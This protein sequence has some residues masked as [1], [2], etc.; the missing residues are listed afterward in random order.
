MTLTDRAGLRYLGRHPWLTA[1][2]ILGIALGVSVV[3]SIDIAN[4][5]ARRSFELSAERVTGRATHHVA[6][7][8]DVSDEVFRRLRVDAGIRP[9]A[10]VVEGF[11]QIQ[12]GTFEVLGVD[13][14]FDRPFRVYATSI[15]GMDL[16]SFL[17][18]GAVVLLPNAAADLLGASV[19]D[20]LT[21]AAAGRT[22]RLVV[23]GL[24]QA[25]NEADGGAL[26]NFIVAD[27]GTAQRLFGM[28]GRLSRIDLMLPEDPDAIGEVES[29]LPEG[30]RLVESGAQTDTI[31]QMTRA[32]EVNLTALSLLALVVGMF[33]IYNTMTFSVVQRR[34][35]I[36]RMR[37]IGVTRSEIFR[38]ILFE[39]GVLG[40]AGTVVGLAGGVALSLSLVRMVTQTIND[41]YYVVD[42]QSV[43]VDP[44]IL[45]KGTAL[46][47]GATI[48][49]A[50]WPAREA[51]TAPV[52]VVLQRSEEEVR[53][54]R[55]LPKL[56]AAA[57]VVGASAAAVFMLSGRSLVGSYVGLLLILV[58]F[59]LITPFILMQFA[60]GVRRIIGWPFGTI[61]RMAAQGV[62]HNLSRTSVATAALSIAV[63]AAVGVGI[64]IG[65]FR[66]T[67]STWLDYTLQADLYVQAPSPVA[68]LGNALL[69][70]DLVSLF[71][72]I[73]GVASVS[74]IRQLDLI[75]DGDPIQL[76][77][78]LAGPNRRAAVRFVD[79]DVDAIWKEFDRGGVIVSEPFTY[80]TGH[81]RGDT[82]ELP[83][84]DGMRDFPVAGVFYDYG[85]DLGM[86]MLSRRFFD[87][88]FDVRGLSGISLY[89]SEGADLARVAA[90]VRAAAGGRDL[91]VRS[92]RDLRTFSLEIF[93]RSFTITAVLRLLALLVAFVGV[94]SAL[95]ALQVEREREFA[96]L[97][98]EGLTPGQLLRYVTLQTS[99]LGTAAG[100][101]SVPLGTLLAFVLVFVINKRSF[102]WT[103][104][105]T[106]EPGILLQAVA[107]AVAASVLAG[108]YPSWRMSRANPADA[109]RG[110]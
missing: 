68:R 91:I 106:I 49:A 92:N 9:S 4:V 93:D 21:A 38:L 109:L 66:N 71:A 25:D 84:S 67:V 65:S 89:A 44:W 110:E 97:R 33:L 47:L 22:H 12:G 16:G 69:D 35:L 41:L 45:V 61:G 103:L 8:E 5:S 88:S 63:A 7:P 30:V 82:L 28:E 101:L 13:P 43:S 83:T 10:P 54:R 100:L 95:M 58:A 74:S 50:L 85:S 86:A 99:I 48:A 1:L 96:V 52:T 19:G 57:V 62:V 107:I 3:V 18:P 42:V 87:R 20:T 73:E 51:A 70:E 60:R 80:R 39:A 56:T 26:A 72:A 34:P 81:E 59:A 94:V 11:V 53:I 6:G 102:G 77:G 2:S 98:A 15:T 76:A 14:F 36:G 64:M 46:G 23:G 32:F 105:L 75:V 24:L 17:G 104:E 40:L 55:A 31:Q 27:I 79:G 78:I 108:I 90:D 37:A 29:A